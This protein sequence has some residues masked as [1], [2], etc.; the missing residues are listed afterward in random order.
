MLVQEWK[1]V[2]PPGAEQIFDNPTDWVAQHIRRY[3][4]SNGE[5][6]HRAYGHDSLLLITRGRR[7]GKLRRTALWYLRDGDRFLLVGS[8]NGSG[9]DP[10]WVHNVSANPAVVAQVRA[11]TFAALARIAT[12]E[13]HTA[14]WERI[15]TEIPQYAGHQRR[16]G[17]ELR[18]VIVEPA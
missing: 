4:E 18:I 2:P 13:E 8:S 7:S 10:A 14:L 12:T 16:A 15:V 17:R 1:P 3:V 9:R 5:K 11:D 6:G